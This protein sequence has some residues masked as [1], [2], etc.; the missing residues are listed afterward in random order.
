MQKLSSHL[1]GQASLD[2]YTSPFFAVSSVA[3][4]CQQEVGGGAS[5]A[6]LFKEGTYETAVAGM[7]E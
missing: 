2:T 1:K 6:G 7:A 5:L 4:T 3:G